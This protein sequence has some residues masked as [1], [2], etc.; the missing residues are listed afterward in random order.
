MRAAH[1]RAL[2]MLAE[3]EW[4]LSCIS[5][6]IRDFLYFARFVAS[7]ARKGFAVLALRR[8]TAG[9]SSSVSAL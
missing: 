9:L 1:S 8:V 5:S 3:R 7:L 6:G 2:A 4:Q